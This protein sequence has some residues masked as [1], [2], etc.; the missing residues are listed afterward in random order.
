MKANLYLFLFFF[1]LLCSGCGKDEP[2]IEPGPDTPDTP[3]ENTS[4]Y[5]PVDWDKADISKMDLATGEV[6]L[7]FTGE[8][9]TFENGLSLVVLETDTSAHLRRVM[10]AKVDGNTVFMQTI[11]A[12]M[13]ELFSDTEFTL[14]VGG[15]QA[16]LKSSNG[17]VYLPTKIIQ[18]DQGGSYEILYDSKT[19]KSDYTEA[20]PTIPLKIYD[21]NTSH[22][23]IESELADLV[24]VSAS[25][26][27]FEQSLY[28]TFSTHFKFGPAT[29]VKEIDKD[30]K[31]PISELEEASCLLGAD[32]VS[33]ALF[34]LSVSRNFKKEGKKQFLPTLKFGFIFTVPAP[35]PVPVYL[36]VDI[37]PHVGYEFGIG[38]SVTA[39]TGY[40]LNG[41]MSLGVS[42]K[43]GEDMKPISTATVN[44]ETHPLEI[45]PDGSYV[46]AR[47]SAYPKVNTMLYGGLGPT[48]T[49][50]P[51][52]EN[53]FYSG[54][55][56]PTF[57]S[58]SDEINGGI[59]FNIGARAEF[60]GIYAE[61]ELGPVLSY[62]GTLYKTPRYIKLIEPA[63]Q[64]EI[65]LNEP[66]KIKFRV[67]GEWTI[68]FLEKTEVPQRMVPVRFSSNNMKL[69]KEFVLTD[70]SGN[71]EVVWTPTEAND[72]LVATTLDYN[73]KELSRAVF[74]PK[75]K[76]EEFS[77]VGKWWWKGG[78]MA[79]EPY[80]QKM[81]DGENYVE[82][83][84]DGTFKEVN[85]PLKNLYG[86]TRNK[87]GQVIGYGIGVFYRVSRGTYT[88]SDLEL[89]TNTTY[90]YD[91]INFDEYDL[92]GNFIQHSN[93]VFTDIPKEDRFG[94]RIEVFDHNN[95]W[96]HYNGNSI[97][98]CERI[99]EIPG[100]KAKA[101]LPS[102][103]KA[104]KH[105]KNPNT[106][107]VTRYD[108][109]P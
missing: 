17:E 72:S 29:N 40:E 26:E 11:E 100:S 90:F 81:V 96:I 86:S 41:N 35:V 4:T 82:F 1:L 12:T 93:I 89:K 9:P 59:E 70:E 24:G 107:I 101:I 80:P 19:T 56:F 5:V 3:V 61:K 25:T 94:G 44:M 28:L 37:E 50:K 42:Y 55:P 33:N 68:P 43:K 62:S 27:K 84:S 67:T 16:Q 92:S 104:P 77:I 71:A 38:G 69:D 109:Q 103:K 83:F 15:G 108:L 23:S 95:I 75:P 6:S 30:F 105:I 39:S 57:Y 88:Y 78:Y 97:H 66:A 8:V 34:S 7:T 98:R 60:M 48:F 52:V 49:L 36:R 18:Y 79:P 87:D 73:G 106:E 64:T 85:N 63:N 58:W 102:Y 54:L 47:L 51:Y 32:L 53:K 76:E 22:F 13:Q 45:R 65:A 74:T 99:K 2:G 10:N 31:V 14:S 91:T 20:I 46:Y 21:L